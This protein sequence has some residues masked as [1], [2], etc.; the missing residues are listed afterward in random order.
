MKFD[1]VFPVLPPLLDGIGDYTACL[2]SALA[3]HGEVRVLAGDGAHAPIARVQTVE[4][5]SVHSLRGV[6]RLADA[7]AE[8][9]PDWLILQYNPFSYGPRGFAPYLPSALVALRKRA[10]QTRVAILVHEPFMPV[11]NWRMALMTTWQRW[12]LWRLGR[13]ADL[14]LFSIQ[15]WA[16]RFSA[17]FPGTPVRHL[18]VGSNIARQ[19]V[20]RKGAR[21]LLGVERHSLVVGVFGSAHPS[22]LLHFVA[23]AAS[24]L[25]AGRFR[26]RLVYVGAAGGRLRA[27]L[28]GQPLIDAGPLPPLEV[29]RC[30]AA[31][32]IYLAPFRKGVSSRR[33]SF[34]VG[35]QHGVATVSTSGIQTD[36]ELQ[37]L[38]GEAYLLAPDDDPDRFVE[39]V[40]ALAAEPEVRARIGEA[41]QR[42]FERSFSWERIVDSLLDYMGESAPR[43]G[44]AVG[45]PAQAPYMI[46]STK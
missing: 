22:R 37:A 7:V 34:M 1:L 29:S 11:E 35:L 12:Q 30:F 20:S 16:E 15:P 28:S 31:M 24:A 43:H 6:F 5:F 42:L 40:L 44:E 17:W 39:R 14:I 41:G 46:E 38:D 33:G 32:D 45:Q 26:P 4:A 23:G 36:A 13:T 27:A 18:P 10:P 19:A 2:A 8:D 25:S 9:P 21:E 3:D